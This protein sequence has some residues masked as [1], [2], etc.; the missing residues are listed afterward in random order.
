LL[1]EAGVEEVLVVALHA[2]DGGVDDLEV[3]GT[4][5]QGGLM[6]AVDGE[7]AGTGLTDDAAFADVLAA[8]FELGL[9]KD[10]GVALPELACGHEGGEDGGKDERGR[11]EGDVHREKRWRGGRISRDELA[12]LEQARVGALAQGDAGV[13]AELFGDLAPTGVDGE[14]AGRAV[15]QHAV[16]EASGA[17]PDVDAGQVGEVDGPVAEGFFELETATADVAE[18]VAEEANGGVHGDGGAGFVDALLVDQDAAGEDEGLSAF[19]GGDEGAVDQQLVETELGGARGGAGRGVRF[20]RH[21]CVAG[22]LLFERIP[23]AQRW[24]VEAGG[25][26]LDPMSQK[27]DMGTLIVAAWWSV[28]E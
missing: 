27:R 11:D 6:D 8:G 9:D 17:G 5:R 24:G 28:F 18:I 3:G 23:F 19:A 21:E 13:V 4:E 7:L 25:S 12:G 16:G 22:W 20:G 26:P 15:L 10:N 14:D 2:V 1:A